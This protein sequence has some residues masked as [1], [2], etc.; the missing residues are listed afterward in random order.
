MIATDTRKV[1]EILPKVKV[2]EDAESLYQEDSGD[3]FWGGFQYVI[4]GIIVLLMTL[5]IGT[6]VAMIII[7]DGGGLDNLFGFI[8]FGIFGIIMLG[9]GC[10][11]LSTGIYNTRVA[12]KLTP[13]RIYFKEWPLKQNDIFE[14]TYRRRAKVPLHLSG[15]TAKI[16]CKEVATYQQGTNTRTVT[17]KIYE[18]ELERVEHHSREDFI[19][20]TWVWNIPPDAPISLS[21]YR[22]EI[23]WSLVVGVEFLDFLNDTS[24]FTLLLNPER[25]Q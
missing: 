1:K 19:S 17:E 11:L 15:L 5:G 6:F 7:D 2:E 24:E 18:Q 20:H 22:N 10:W 9:V 23:Q 8:C 16:I 12:I 3:T 21:V 4:G 25:V 13:G 14:F